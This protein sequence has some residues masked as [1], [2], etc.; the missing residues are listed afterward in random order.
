M[1]QHER[2]HKNQ[3]SE[4]SEEAN[5]RRSK[6]AITRDAQKGK[7]L[8]K[9]ESSESD[10]ATQPSTLQSPLSEV[11]S[12]APSL[13]APIPMSEAQFYPTEP[14]GSILPIMPIQTLAENLSPNSLYPL[15][16]DENL[17]IPINAIPPPL[18]EKL[19]DLSTLAPVTMAPPLIRGFSDLDTLAQAA[20]TFDP[21]YQPTM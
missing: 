20:E 3:G 18:P 12:I 8:K 19:A 4:G 16:A 13:E 5:P 15:I 9:Q 17:M 14:I 7:Q 1:K 11:T 10:P 21:Y 6:A 2:T